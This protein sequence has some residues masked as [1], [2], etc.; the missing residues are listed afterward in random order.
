[1]PESRLLP[2]SQS[3]CRT[4]SDPVKE[5]FW[6]ALASI[7][8]G[9]V[10]SYGTLARLAG[11]GRGARLAG[12]W[13]GQLPEGSSLPWHRVVNSQG[14]LSLPADSPAGQEQFARLTEEGV[15]IRNRRIDMKRYGWPD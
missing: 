9:R 4:V 12:R 8:H 5:A 3:D 1:M 11:L 6:A 14:R 10:C 7:P 13:L 2:A 15:S